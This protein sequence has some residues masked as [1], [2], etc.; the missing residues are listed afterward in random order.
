MA[1]ADAIQWVEAATPNV[2]RISG[3]VVKG[4]IVSGGESGWGTTR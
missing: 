3:R 1:T 2:P 4:S